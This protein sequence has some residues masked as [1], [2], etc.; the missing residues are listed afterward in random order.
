MPSDVSLDLDVYTCAEEALFVLLLLG[1][2]VLLLG[3]TILGQTSV[4]SDPVQRKR[5]LASHRSPDASAPMEA[6][7]TLE[8]A[9]KPDI[10]ATITPAKRKDRRASV[11]RQGN[12]VGVVL[13]AG[14][15]SRAEPGLVIDRSTGGLCL[16]LARPWRSEPSCKYAPAKRPKTSPISDWR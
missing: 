4:A 13:L 8:V 5:F 10:A 16:S 6:N 12:P 7:S 3:N 11:R 14:E 9:E 15:G 2:V 1:G